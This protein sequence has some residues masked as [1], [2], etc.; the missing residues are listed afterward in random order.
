MFVEIICLGNYDGLIGLLE[1]LQWRGG[2]GAMSRVEIATTSF[3]AD[4][5]RANSRMMMRVTKYHRSA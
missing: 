2:E 4:M 5:A 3:M 1:I